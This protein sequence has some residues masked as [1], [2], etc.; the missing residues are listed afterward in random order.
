[1]HAAVQDALATATL[2]WNGAS[3]TLHC[4]TEG[5]IGLAPLV[6]IH[7]ELGTGLVGEPVHGAFLPTLGTLLPLAVE[8][9]WDAEYTLSGPITLPLAS[10]PVEASL[11][12]GRLVIISR[13]LP[14]E[15]ISLSFGQLTALPVE[16]FA[17]VDAQVA[18]PDGA[19]HGITIDMLTLLYFVEE[20]GLMRVR[21]EGGTIA[22]LPQGAISLP[23]DLALARS[24]P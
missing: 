6:V 12:S 18:L 7:P 4:T 2:T 3:G 22:G 11:E 9:T 20:I 17:F 14:P 13:T 16:Q 15:V 23:S 24:T 10:G 19:T 21:Y 5:L 1:L 8:S